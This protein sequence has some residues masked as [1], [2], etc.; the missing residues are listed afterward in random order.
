L[1]LVALLAFQ[2]ILLVCTVLLRLNLYNCLGDDL[3]ALLIIPPR[4]LIV[5]AEIFNMI[6]TDDAPVEG[7]LIIV[8]LVVRFGTIKEDVPKWEQD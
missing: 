3:N 7:I 1:S 2:D 8:N 4:L 6:V 5:V